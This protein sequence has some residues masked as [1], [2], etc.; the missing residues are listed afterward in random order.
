WLS[1]TTSAPVVEPLVS[2]AASESAPPDLWH[3]GGRH[4]G[5]W[6]GLLLIHGLTPEGKRDARLTWTA[7][8]LARAGLAVAVPELP[9]LRAQRLRPEDALVVRDTLD[10]L[11]QDPAV[12]RG[13]AAV[14]AVSVGLGPLAVA[15][16]EP[17]LADR[18]RVA[19][20]LGGYAD[21][22]EL[23]RYFTTGT[24][25]FGATAGRV[26]VDP[27]LAGAF[28]AR[29]LDLVS[30][31]RDRAAVE[32]ALQGRAESVDVGPGARAVLAVL[33]NRDPARVEALLDALP[34]ATRELL[35]ALSPAQHLG[36]TR[37]RFL[38]VHGP[39]DRAIPFTGSP[40]PAAAGPDR[41]PPL[42]P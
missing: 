4:R 7:G 23:V 6:P 20:T 42:I 27:G 11:A 22:R 12:Q 38:V 32:D 25:A 16:D 13:P 35:E 31:A 14:I 36:R 21:A 30:D 24:Y 29:N 5:P 18:V 10:R 33:Q 41:S 40:P 1:R 34:A 2:G 15:L 9:A 17:A 37:A 19:V 26:D 3:P 8:L 39:Q 28:L